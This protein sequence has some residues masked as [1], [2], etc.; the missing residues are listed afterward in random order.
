MKERTHYCKKFG[1]EQWKY[2]IFLL[3]NGF[4]LCFL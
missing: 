1:K 4:G 3:E 2:L